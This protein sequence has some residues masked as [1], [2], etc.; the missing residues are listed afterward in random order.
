MFEQATAKKSPWIQRAC[1]AVFGWLL[2]LMLML[3]AAGPFSGRKK[4]DPKDWTR[5]D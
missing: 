2:M 4:S 3:M 5:E 1:G